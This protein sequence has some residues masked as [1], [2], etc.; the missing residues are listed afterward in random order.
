[1]PDTLQTAMLRKNACTTHSQQITKHQ[2]G[3]Q[4]HSEAL[5]SSVLGAAHAF[6]I[7]ISGP[8]QSLTTPHFLIVLTSRARSSTTNHKSSITND[9]PWHQHPTHIIFLR[10]SRQSHRGVPSHPRSNV[11]PRLDRSPRPRPCLVCRPTRRGPNNHV[12]PG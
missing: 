12:V 6:P 1:M 3:K 10:E 11:L 4:A 9:T 7:P 5:R 2:H 8:V